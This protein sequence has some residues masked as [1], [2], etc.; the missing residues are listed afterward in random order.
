M[1]TQATDVA[2][3][4]HALPVGT[5]TA[6]SSMLERSC[7]VCLGPYE[8]EEEFLTL[9][10]LH[11]YHATCIAGWMRQ[12]TTCPICLNPVLDALDS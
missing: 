5:V 1:Q 12:R 6:T 3:I 7:Q 8:I 11:Q 2:R 10:C 4:M 9:P